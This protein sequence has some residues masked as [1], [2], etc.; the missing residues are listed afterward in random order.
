[1]SGNAVRG[2][3]LLAML[4]DEFERMREEIERLRK[5]VEA[6]AEHDYE[7]SYTPELYARLHLYR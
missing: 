5:V 6:I 1:M 7:G 3:R 4:D 2:R